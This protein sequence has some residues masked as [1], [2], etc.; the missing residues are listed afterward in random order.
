M[1]GVAIKYG[2]FAPD[3]KE[4]FDIAVSDAE[5]FFDKT[6][7]QQYNVK[8]P[9]YCNPCELYSVVLDGTAE[10][11]PSVPQENNLGL[12]ST[13]VSKQDRTFA[14]PVVLTLTS[15]GQ[16]TSQGLTFTFDTYNDIYP[17]NINIRWFRDAEGTL[18][19]LSPEGGIDYTPDNAF[20]FCQ[21]FVENYN[22]VVITF[23]ALNMPYNRLKL[24]SI[25]YGYGTVFYGD[26]LRNVNVIQD[27]DPISRAISI[28]TVDFT[29][30]SKSNI[31]YSFQAKQPLTVYFNNK[32]I[33]T[34]FID[35]SKRK[36][37]RL[38]NVQ[39]EDYIGLMD[40]IPFAGGIYKN[41][42]AFDLLV[43][44]FDIAKVPYIIDEIFKNKTV[45]GYI[46]Y[47]TCRE[48]LKQVAFAI[49]ACVDTSNS[50]KVKVFKLVNEVSQEIPLERVMQGQS[51]EDSKT[52]TSVELSYFEYAPKEINDDNRIKLY[53]SRESGTGDNILIKFSE[54]IHDI[55]ING[56]CEVLDQGTNFIKVN[57]LEGNSAVIGGY[58][59]D[60]I[61]NVK[62][63]TNPEKSANEIEN[64]E[65]ISDMTL[66]SADNVSEILD[67]CYDYLTNTSQ[68]SM[69]IVEGKHVK[70]GEPYRWGMVKW[71]E[72]TWGGT[73][74]KVITYDKV[75]DLGDVIKAKNQYMGDV[76]GRV[77]SEK[78]HLNGS[79]LIKE[80]VV[81]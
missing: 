34:M 22:R 73:E 32:L 4:N 58:G 44:I 41:K 30:D 2:D 21:Y 70:G 39:S 37:E 29:L 77:I 75:V 59:Y 78:Y 68:T 16:Y 9:N 57:I 47:T 3:A 53:D 56:D 19:E 67:I 24:R 20:Y 66:I 52:V 65:T 76:R 8:F 42:N 18:T 79:I 71:G 10:A 31:V 72:F 12:W 45:S 23:K 50:E 54:P 61:E 11:F 33:Q 26:E 35:N 5:T 6:Q 80:A 48:A 38:W 25:D 69:K 28:N 15:R 63:K 36:A 81:K 27:I 64:I 13:Q 17:T 7:L 51:F 40:N 1:N 60:V 43:E 46:K 49:G 62:I 55:F 14:E 74:P